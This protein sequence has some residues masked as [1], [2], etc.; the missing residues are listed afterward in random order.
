MPIKPENAKRYPLDWPQIREKIL[1]RAWWCCEN[2]GVQNHAWGWRDAEGKF[3]KINKGVIRDTWPKDERHT[4]KPPFM[5]ATDKG[6]VKIIE[7][8]LTVAHL[9]HQPENCTPENLRAWCQKCHLAYDHEHHQQNAYQTRRQG[10]AVGDM[11]G[12][13][14]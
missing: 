8:V 3:H 14:P 6:D 13:K 9:D 10:K 1:R 5:L 11:F 7:I 12:D 2:C 4:R